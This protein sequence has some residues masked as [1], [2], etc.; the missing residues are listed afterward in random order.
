MI[1]KLDFSS[2]S[3]TE[4]LEA[5]EALWESLTHDENEL[6]SPDWHGEIIKQRK[7]D[8][9]NG[10]AEYISVKDLKTK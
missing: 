2:L 7:H 10:S 5:M 1:M 6:T 8:I 4:R 3:S 9:K